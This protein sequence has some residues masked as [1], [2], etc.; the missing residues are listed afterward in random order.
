VKEIMAPEVAKRWGAAALCGVR[1]R[2][3]AMALRIVVDVQP[4]EI[5]PAAFAA[6]RE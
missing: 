6:R 2:F 1:L 4:Q 5:R 3:S